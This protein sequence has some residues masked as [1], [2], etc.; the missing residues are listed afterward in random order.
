MMAIAE[1]ASSFF[2]F[3]SIRCFI[4]IDGGDFVATDWLMKMR[5]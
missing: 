2:S 3:H 1:F 4:A 5:V